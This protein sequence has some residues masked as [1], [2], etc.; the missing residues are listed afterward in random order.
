MLARIDL[1]AVLF[2]L[3]A[4]LSGCS[5]LE[6]RDIYRPVASEE[7]LLNFKQENL[8]L[9]I[10][11]NPDTRLGS[12]GLL[13]LPI[14]PVYAKTAD[15]NEITLAIILQLRDARD[16]SL[17]R[18]PCLDIES[19]AVICPY[20]VQ[21]SAVGLFR[22]MAQCIKTSENDGTTSRTFMDAKIECFICR[23]RQMA[24]A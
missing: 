6:V 5:T 21:V 16:F 9:R 15:P 1:R 17:S 24:A 3:A 2:A 4:G 14:I 7:R 18:R 11:I 8:E 19:S 22:M 10:G 12:V 23:L 13:G 20:Q